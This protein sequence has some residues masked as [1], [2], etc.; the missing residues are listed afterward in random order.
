MERHNIYIYIYVVLQNIVKKCSYI[1]TYIHTKSEEYL[2]NNIVNIV[3]LTPLN[4][5]RRNAENIKHNFVLFFID[6]LL[7][8]YWEKTSPNLGHKV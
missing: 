1:Y 2:L 3:T 7:F 4:L 6:S 5:S 8:L